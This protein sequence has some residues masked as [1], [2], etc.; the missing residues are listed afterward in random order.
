MNTNNPFFN[1]F[2]GFQNYE[3]NE[4]N[5]EKLLNKI[6][7]LEKSIRIL[8]NQINK[9]EKKENNKSISNEPTDMYMI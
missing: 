3:Q 8:E 6:D 5:Y 9:Q 1:P 2:I 4:I 7:R